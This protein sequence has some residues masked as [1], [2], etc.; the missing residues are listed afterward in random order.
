MKKEIETKFFV[1]DLGT[2][3]KKLKKLG[4][5]FEGVYYE[6]DFMFDNKRGDLKRNRE[7]LRIRKSNDISFLTFKTKVKSQEG[8]KIADEHQI[9]IS[10]A[11]ALK[12]IFEHLGFAA[13]FKYKKPRREYWKYLDSHVTLDSFPFGKFV[14]VEGMEKRIRQIAAKLGFDFDRS[15]AKSYRRLIEE[16][17][18]Y[19]KITY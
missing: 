8:F 4:A 6:H 18:K 14:E 10:N 19:K 5:K 16:Y 9:E 13:V 3:R 12:K 17:R 11:L 1:D 2:V 15:S 7:V